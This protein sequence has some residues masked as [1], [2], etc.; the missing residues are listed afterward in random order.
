MIL[1]LGARINPPRS[2]RRDRGHP[3][4]FLP[5]RVLGALR[6]EGKPSLSV[7]GRSKQLGLG[8]GRQT[9]VALPLHQIE[10]RGNRPNQAA[11]VRGQNHRG[12]PQAADTLGLSQTPAFLR[13]GSTGP[14]PDPV[15]RMAWES[16]DVR[17]PPGTQSLKD[18]PAPRRVP[19]SSG[20]RAPARPP[21]QRE[22]PGASSRSAP[23]LHLAQPIPY[24]RT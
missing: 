17:V 9:V 16:G 12:Q 7:A 24:A 10:K 23:R 21:A 6:G 5:L 13:G 3:F 14:P 2:S 15:H 22:V 18:P 19:G 11:P 20:R 8:P 1:M 4:A